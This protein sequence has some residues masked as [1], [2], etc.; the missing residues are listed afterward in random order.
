ML[1][2]ANGNCSMALVI[3]IKIK[4]TEQLIRTLQTDY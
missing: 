3:P 2:Q 1:K 4:Q